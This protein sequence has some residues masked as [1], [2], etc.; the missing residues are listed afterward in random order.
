[1]KLKS[2]LLVV[3]LLTSVVFAATT[4]EQANAVTTIY[5]EV[6]RTEAFVV[7]CEQ[8]FPNTRTANRKAFEEWKARNGL[9]DFNFVLTNF[10]QRSPAFT[11]QLEKVRDQFVTL[12]LKQPDAK[13]EPI[14]KGLPATLQQANSNTIKADYAKELA[15]IAEVAQSLRNPT[16]NSSATDTS[17][18]T[19]PATSGNSVKGAAFQTKPGAGLKPSQIEGLYYDR[20]QQM[21]MDGFGNSYINVDESTYLVLRDGGVYRYTWGFPPEDFNAALSKREEPKR[22][23][24]R[25]ELKR[26]L[27]DAWKMLPVKSGFTF[28]HSFGS[29]RTGSGGTISEKSISFK[30]NGQFEAFGYSTV[31][32]NAYGGGTGSTS[33]SGS[34]SS[35]TISSNGAGQTTISTT[36]VSSSST[37]TYNLSGYAVT[38]KFSDGS[39]SRFVFGIP[40]FCN[41]TN[42]GDVFFR[43][44]FW[45]GSS[46]KC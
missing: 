16:N 15:I 45:W 2:H 41:Q 26:T 37:G 32:G 11:A 28:S 13:L 7:A 46:K 23:K 6:A 24:T 14:C 20:Q 27:E 31:A 35:T 25:A 8:R 39:T 40:E 34:G 21:K 12:I 3:A 19:P 29:S 38:L 44:T 1:M 22:W 9:Q 17:S 18:S 5:T 4:E 36:P 10:K 42:P 43:G 33:I 30:S